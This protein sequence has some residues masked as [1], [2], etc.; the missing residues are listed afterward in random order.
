MDALSSGSDSDEE[1]EVGLF[2]GGELFEDVRTRCCGVGC[3][4]LFCSCLPLGVGAPPPLDV[5]PPHQSTT[6]TGPSLLSQV[7]C[8]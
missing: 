8:C 6:T 5:L 4:C 2:E 1:D 3:D 7:R